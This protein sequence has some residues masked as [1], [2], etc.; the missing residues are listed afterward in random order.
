VLFGPTACCLPPVTC[1]LLPAACC[2]LLAAC[3]L[4]PAACYLLP[5]ACYL[6]PAAYCLLPAACYL[7]PAA[8]YLL[9]AACYLLPAAPHPVRFI[10]YKARRVLDVA[11]KCRVDFLQNVFKL[12]L[13]WL[14]V[15][16]QGWI[17]ANLVSWNIIP[18]EAAAASPTTGWPETSS[19][20]IFDAPN[21]AREGRKVKEKLSG[22]FGWPVWCQSYYN[23][24]LPSS[25]WKLQ[26]M[27]SSFRIEVTAINYT[28]VRRHV[29]QYTLMSEKTLSLKNNVH[30]MILLFKWL[31]LSYSGN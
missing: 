29:P 20:S 7:L 23:F 14:D 8:C 13:F 30:Q 12:D 19:T 21:V 26:F 17:R 25:G 27:I 6:Q 10:G 1:C 15:L 22:G 31:L 5:A 3:C 28:T 2:L 16:L 11:R 9:P 18:Q 4:L 24:V